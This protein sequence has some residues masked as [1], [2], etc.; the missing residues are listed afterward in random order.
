MVLAW[1]VYPVLLLAL[2]AGLGL[3]L[4]AACGQRLPGTL[5]APV[6]LATLVLLAQVASLLG[7]SV[8]AVASGTIVLAGVGVA[9]SMPW[10]FDRPDRWAALAALAV[11]VLF[12]LPSLLS[13]HPT[14]AVYGEEAEIERWLL[15]GASDPV[16][17]IWP[18]AVAQRL[19]GGELAWHLQPYIAVLGALLALGAWELADRADAPASRPRAAV[20]FVTALPALVFG[21]AG[22]GGMQELAALAV[23]APLAVLALEWRDDRQ[24]LRNS[25]PL[26]V[27]FT[28]ALVLLIP[29]SPLELDAGVW[30]ATAGLAAFTAATLAVS[31]WVAG[32]LSPLALGLFAA[33][34]A[35]CALVASV[36]ATTAPYGRL[37]EL[38]EI[39]AVFADEGPTLLFEE[40]PYAGYFLR[41]L[42]LADRRPADPDRVHF[43]EL[44]GYPLLIVPRVPPLSR[45][46][47]PY[48]RRYLG[49]DFEVWQLP[50]DPTFSLLFHM[51]LGEP[52]SPAALPDCSSTV[53]L[54]LLALSGQLGALP[55]DTALA[56]ASP[57][58]GARLGRVVFVS[59]SEARKLCGH[60]WDWIEAIG[61]R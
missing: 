48:K 28:A 53:G 59:T 44:L 43:E 37:S 52:G 50:S 36:G 25:L 13:G 2:C 61:R 10:S 5:I 55:Q 14:F 60:R 1:L 51:S 15:A 31:L 47:L 9:V 7:A 35:A 12:A 16:G 21:Y 11:F 46:A 41:D 56:A 22:W 8:A 39:N 57:R 3:L 45:P 27:T 38:G 19:L 58:R 6:G 40:E 29:F 26:A 32:A 23:L 42:D 49:A 4:D 30:L 17:A 20:A 33:V 24:G 18:L 34:L 54:G